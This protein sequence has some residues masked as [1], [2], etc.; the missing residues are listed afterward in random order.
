MFDISI[1]HILSSPHGRRHAGG[2][3][4][5]GRA[6]GLGHSE[7]LPLSPKINVVRIRRTKN[8]PPIIDLR[9]GP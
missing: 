2:R 7:S 9:S 4:E 8:P 5:T 1:H 3:P 6:G